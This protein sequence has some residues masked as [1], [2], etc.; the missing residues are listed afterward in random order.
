MDTA[1]SRL[2]PAF[3]KLALLFEKATVPWAKAEAAIAVT[4]SMLRYFFIG[5]FFLLVFGC[6]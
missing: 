1:L 4:A 3:T 6:L 2:A 5:Y